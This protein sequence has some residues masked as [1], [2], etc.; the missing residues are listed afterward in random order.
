LEQQI[1]VLITDDHAILREGLAS[2]IEKQADILVV[3]EAEDGNECLEKV[4]VLVPDVVVM[5]IKVQGI[6]GIEACRRLKASFP[7]MKVIILSMYE[8]YEYVNRALQVGADGYLLKK[9]A[10][11]ELV[12]AIRKAYQGEKVFS[13]QVLEM[14]V[15]SY[16]MEVEPP[17]PPSPIK[18][19]TAREFDVLSLISEGL[20]NKEIAANL[21]ISTKTVEKVI[22]GIFRKLGVSSR[23]AAVKLFLT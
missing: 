7:L 2:L 11:S 16:K 22:S 13:P 5:D 20:S 10:S 18:S 3:G 21:C 15:D 14:I 4:A 1:R 8:D 9:V 19:L 23:T 6:S 17:E 12:N